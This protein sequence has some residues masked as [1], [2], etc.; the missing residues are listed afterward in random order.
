MEFEKLLESLSIL[1]QWTVTFS[2]DTCSELVAYLYENFT[3]CSKNFGKPYPTPE[4]TEQDQASPGSQSFHLKYLDLAPGE[5]KYLL[6]LTWCVSYSDQLKSFYEAMFFFTQLKS[7][8]TT[9][10]AI[11]MAGW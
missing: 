7:S 1:W 2:T 10:M 3:R 9:E 8:Y 11:S 4:G 6:S 5:P